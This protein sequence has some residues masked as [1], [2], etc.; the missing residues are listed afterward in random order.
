MRAVVMGQGRRT[1][2]Q[3]FWLL[4]LCLLAVLAGSRATAGEADFLEPER[5]FQ[6]SAD[7]PAA[8]LLELR[9]KVA[10]GYY[11]YRERFELASQPESS[12]NSAAAVFPTG[13]VKYDPTFEKDME[14]Y[15]Q[16][17]L[18]RVPLALAGQP[19][20]LRVTSQGCADAGLCYPPM[21]HLVTL[22]PQG[23]G[24]AIQVSAIEPGQEAAALAGAAAAPAAAPAS[25][26]G[27]LLAPAM[28][29]WPGPSA[30]WA[31]SARPAC[32]SYWACCL[33]SRPACCP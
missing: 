33:P 22:A 12:I 6:L 15:H 24:Y 19:A 1:G 13:E 5:A 31:S 16:D 9:F 20:R 25:G 27:A 2:W 8:D 10:P 32:S 28:S 17:V 18:I 26:L 23:A 21:S 29:A 3:V 30:A 11:M 7:Q 4:A 14:V